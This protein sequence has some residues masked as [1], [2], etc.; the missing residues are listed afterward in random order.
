MATKRHKEAQKRG[1]KRASKTQLKREEREEREE[2]KGR[3]GRKGIVFGLGK[4][5][6]PRPFLGNS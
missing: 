4:V 5:V 6:C 3:K 1:I 2:R